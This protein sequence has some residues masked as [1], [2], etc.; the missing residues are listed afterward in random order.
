MTAC[1]RSVIWPRLAGAQARSGRFAEAERLIAAT[2]QDCYPRMEARAEIVAGDRRAAVAPAP[3]LPSA[4]QAWGAALP[5]RGGALGF[6]PAWTALHRAR[7]AAG[8]RVDR[9]RR[10]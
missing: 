6:A 1:R 10:A 7:E 9:G 3:S 5:A 4:C 8:R 2:Q